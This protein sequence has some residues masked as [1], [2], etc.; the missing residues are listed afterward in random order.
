MLQGI[1]LDNLEPPE[2]QALQTLSRLAWGLLPEVATDSST[3]TK[4]TLPPNYA[5]LYKSQDETD[6]R[7]F[8]N[9]NN[10]VKSISLRDSTDTDTD[11][12][13]KVSSDDT[14]AGYLNGKLVAGT[15][16]TFTENNGGANETLT[17]DSSASFVPNNIQAFTSSGTWTKPAGTSSVYVKCWGAGGGGG[18]GK[19]GV[20]GG[21][22]GGG[23][24]YRE[25]VI[26]VSGN[27]TVTV[28][29]GGAGGTGGGSPTAGTTGGSSSFAGDST[30]T[31]N[32][33]A[34]GQGQDG[35]A[36][37]GGGGSG[38][39]FGITGESGTTINNNGGEGALGGRGGD[40]GVTNNAGEG[41]YTPGG[42]GGGG[43]SNNQNGGAGA[44]GLVIVYY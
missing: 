22:G 35:G 31:A 9:I 23:G 41:G 42:G 4:D 21:D 13:A 6:Y 2:R 37:G 40:S 10:E 27:V 19:S 38:G 1:R 24:G 16:I 20:A 30:I 17:I 33:G 7:I 32:G 39:S 5:Q 15:G 36:G 14:T 43:G 11:E 26:I 3:I 18:G 28:G 25:G 12:K 29:A 34:G 44:S 8:I